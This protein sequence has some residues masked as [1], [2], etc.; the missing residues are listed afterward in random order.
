MTVLDTLSSDNIVLRCF[1]TH[2]G[3]LFLKMF[4]VVFLTVFWR[5]RKKVSYLGFF[6]TDHFIKI[7]Y[8]DFM[9]WPR[10]ISPQII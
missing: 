8:V 5:I 3:V 4:F 9:I 2:S 10:Y 6:I 1:I 7:K